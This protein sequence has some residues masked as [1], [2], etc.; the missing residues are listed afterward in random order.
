M[1]SNSFNYNQKCLKQSNIIKTNNSP[2][3]EA[4]HKYLHFILVYHVSA[5]SSD[6]E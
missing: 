2:V 1:L 3:A 6:V 5:K 4:V